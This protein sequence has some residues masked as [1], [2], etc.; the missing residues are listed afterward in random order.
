[1]TLYNAAV[2]GF[3]VLL[4]GV[5]AVS[6]YLVIESVREGDVASTRAAVAILVVAFLLAAWLLW[7]LV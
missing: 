3:L 6:V 4:T 1:V 7:R 5:V 2:L